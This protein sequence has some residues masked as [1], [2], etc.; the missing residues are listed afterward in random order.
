M[1][2][3]P[4]SSQNVVSRPSN[5]ATLTLGKSAQTFSSIE[6]RSS[7]V[8]SRPRDLDL[9]TPT[10]TTTSSKSCEALEMMSMW[11][12]VTGS[13]EP[14][15]TARRITRSWSSGCVIG[16]TMARRV[17]I[18]ANVPEHGLA[19]RPF[20]LAHQPLWPDRLPAARRPLHDEHEPRGQPVMR[21]Q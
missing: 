1:A 18:G 4:R 21:D 7:A 2:P 9:L 13:N 8:N 15:Q 16:V 17:G 14:G 11:P 6:I 5:D 3:M 20:A 10:A 12:L 19:V